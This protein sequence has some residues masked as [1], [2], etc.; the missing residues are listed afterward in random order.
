MATESGLGALGL[1][2]IYIIG[3]IIDFAVL[4]F[5]LQKFLYQ[6]VLKKLEER[7]K[8]NKKGLEASEKLIKQQE[9]WEIEQKKL[10]QN[11]QAKTAELIAQG[12]EQAKQEKEKILVEAHQEAQMAA[13]S[14]YAKV[15][16][17]LKEQEKSL[18][19]KIGQLVTATTRKLLSEYLDPKTQ[20]IIL[21]KQLKKLDQFKGQ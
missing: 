16:Q 8:Q 21:K 1:N 3:Q 18:Q 2:P 7:A 13:Q 17:K 19:E 12:Q 20:E 4:F 6:P 5:V 14:E 10:L 11:V 15:E 9:Q